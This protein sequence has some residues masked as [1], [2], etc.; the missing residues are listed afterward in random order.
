MPIKD[1]ANERELFAMRYRPL[2]YLSAFVRALVG[3]PE[4][5]RV[6]QGTNHTG[7]RFSARH[8]LSQ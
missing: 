5:A 2:A 6:P 7:L 8:P 4:G 3:A 1:A